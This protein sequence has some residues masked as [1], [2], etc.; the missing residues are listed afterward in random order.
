MI[1]ITGLGP[2]DFD[3][4]PEAVRAILTDPGRKVI[5][6]TR[7]HPAARR[8]AEMRQVETCDDLYEASVTF[9]EAKETQEN[10]SKAVVEAGY[11][12]V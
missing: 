1:T 7:E 6:R 3:R 2:G 4:I 12:V 8:L 11:K 9:D 5:I 10:M